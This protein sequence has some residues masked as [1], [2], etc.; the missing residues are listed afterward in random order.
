MERHLRMFAKLGLRSTDLLLK[1]EMHAMLPRNIVE[2]LQKYFVKISTTTK[3]RRTP[4]NNAKDGDKC[5]CNAFDP[6]AE[7]PAFLRYDI[8]GLIKVR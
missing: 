8:F 2:I 6:E 4:T 5:D 1:T 7:C 3:W